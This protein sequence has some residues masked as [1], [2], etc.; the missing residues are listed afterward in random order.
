MISGAMAGAMGYLTAAQ[1]GFVPPQMLAW[2]VSATALV[3]VLIGGKNT[4]SGP[5]IGAILLLL[6]E[7]MLQRWTEHWLFGVGLIIVVVVIAA[8]NG[9]VPYVARLVRAEARRHV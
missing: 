3:M 7:E 8:P 4:T 9:I 2:H 5:A 1:D 6:A